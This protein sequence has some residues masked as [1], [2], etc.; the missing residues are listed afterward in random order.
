MLRTRVLAVCTNTVVKRTQCTFYY[1]IC[2]KCQHTVRYDIN[3]ILLVEYIV[4][5][6]SP[7]MNSN[8]TQAQVRLIATCDSY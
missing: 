6:I 7:P 5:T 3:S 1:S 2:T 8:N 4:G